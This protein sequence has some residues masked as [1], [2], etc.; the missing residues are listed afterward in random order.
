MAHT[1]EAGGY[2]FEDLEPGR[3][4]L[5]KL[6]DDLT[7]TTRF[8]QRDEA[9][10]EPPSAIV[11]AG[12][13]TRLDLDPAQAGGGV[14]AGRLRFGAQ[15]TRTWTAALEASGN[16]RVV[17]LDEQG[18]FRIE[19][20]RLGPA[21]LVLSDVPAGGVQH[22]LRTA[23][24]LERGERALAFDYELASVR[25]RAPSHAGQELAL[26]RRDGAQQAF[27]TRFAVDPT[28]QFG[29]LTLCAGH[30]AAVR[31]LAAGQLGPDLLLELDLAA[32]EARALDLP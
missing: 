3:W 18:R 4:W 10:R 32:G 26:V 19:F 17:P 5:R 1:D 7:G 28:G 12:S 20:E 13:T 6:E 23:L 29:P 11:T 14:L 24:E 25:G 16:R 31:V 27:V 9:W 22:E 21:L 15:P 2:R 8:R 30:L